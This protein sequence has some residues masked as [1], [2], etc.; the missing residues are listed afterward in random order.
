M[1]DIRHREVILG[2]LRMHYVESGPEDGTPVILLHGFPEFWYGWRHQ[3]PALSAAGYRVIAPDQ[4]G[5]NLS[6]KPSKAADYDLDIL[7]GDINAL[8]DEL[9]MERFHLVGH[10]W[11][12]AVAWWLALRFPECLRTLSILNVPHPWVISRHLRR[13]PCQ[14]FRSWY[15]FFFQIP[16][17]PEFLLGSGDGAGLANLLRRSGLPG[18][19]MPEDMAMYREAWRQPGALRG[20]ISW[21]RA[22]L[23]RARPPLPT[24][25]IEL[26]VQILWGRQDVALQ[27]EMAEESLAYCKDGR[28][29]V[30]PDATHWVQ[31][32]EAEAVNQR[33]VEFLGAN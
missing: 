18:T 15:I 12:A 1:L 2:G 16:W 14:L 5:Y 30:F 13:D 28:L 24:G 26:P 22:L 17:L 9:G 10:D 7:A 23:R 21:Y 31:H 19:F 3:I 27:V 4:R 32:D 25:R 8:T 20:M 29:E 11:G 33:L 6:D